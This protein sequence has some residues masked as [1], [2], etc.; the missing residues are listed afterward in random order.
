MK[1]IIGVAV[2]SVG[3]LTVAIGSEFYEVLTA[4]GAWTECMGYC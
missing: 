3:L 1:Y 2:F 4:V